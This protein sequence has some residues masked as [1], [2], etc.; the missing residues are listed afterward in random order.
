MSKVKKKVETCQ[1]KC[2]TQDEKH[3]I[4]LGGSCNPTTWR[5]D[6]AIPLLNDRGITFYNPQVAHWRHELIEKEH[7]AKQNASVLFYVID[8]K[9]RNVVGIIEAANFAGSSRKLVLVVNAYN[10]DGHRINGESISDQELIDLR[11]SLDLLK[12]LMER[13]GIPTF[14]NI[15]IAVKCAEEILHERDVTK[16]INTQDKILTQEID[17]EL[18]TLFQET[19]SAFD[20]RNSGTI[21][22]DDVCRA[23]GRI[24]RE[25]ISIGDLRT[26]LPQCDGNGSSSV[27]F[28]QFCSILGNRKSTDSIEC[29]HDLYLTGEGADWKEQIAKPLLRKHGLSYFIPE[30]Y[31]EDCF[32][33]LCRSRVLLFVISENS[34]ALTTMTKAAFALG[35]KANVI[36][37]IQRLRT[38][39]KINGCE[40]LSDQAIQ[41]YNRGRDYLTDL[42]KR[43]N[44]PIYSDIEKAVLQAIYQAEFKSS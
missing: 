32:T 43:N 20:T 1:V 17:E 16:C 8:N 18:V 33:A 13:Q 42:G 38:D 23:Y 35:L 15:P 39:S 9:T 44:V 31:K 24:Y 19:F 3:Q 40:K 26:V 4:F 2:I 30:L 29:S 37:C 21:S 34:R 10:G 11:K 27:S 6:E 12:E 25:N 5:Q 7:Q 28:Q 14:E 36:L 41:D 22:L